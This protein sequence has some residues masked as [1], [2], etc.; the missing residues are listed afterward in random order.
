MARIAFGGFLH[1]VNS[2]TD[3]RAN[4]EYFDGNPAR[5]PFLKGG[6]IIASLQNSGFCPA[7]FIPAWTEQDELVPLVWA[8]GGAGGLVTR[9]AFERIVGELVGR[10]SMAMP[11]DGV[12]V[13]LHGAMVSEDFD[14]AE[15]EILRRIRAVVGPSIPVV[16]SLD[17]HAN[18]SPE[19]AAYCDAMLVYKTYPH[20]DR[21]ETGRRAAQALR[22]LLVLGPAKGRAIRHA[23][24][25]MALDF[26]CTFVEPSKSIVQWQPDC[27]DGLISTSYA[28]GFPP[29]DTVWCG[30]SIVV[31]ALDQASAE[32]AADAY[33]AYFKSLESQFCG[34]L[35]SA[36]EGVAEAKRL[37]STADKP[38][39]LA[40][41]C[42]NP[43]AG[44]TGNTT[45]IIR[46]LLASQA[47]GAVV[48]Y[49]WDPIAA[50]LAFD[51]G[52][53]KT[54]R[55][56]LGEQHPADGEAPL[57]RDFKVVS[58]TDRSY[59]MSGLMARGLEVDFGPMALVQCD[60]V[61]VAVLSQRFQA[62]DRE[63]F[64][65]LG[66]DLTKVKILVLKSSCHFRA[67]FGSLTDTV[68]TVVAP[69]A[70]D[71][72]PANYAYTKLRAGVRFHPDT[73]Q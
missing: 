51:A 34:K 28:A 47:E 40:D 1:E 44:G 41:T 73:P 21:P 15:G 54:V 59:T 52:V 27:S 63:P 22:Q 26:Q 23:S 48:G 67:D 42:D 5:P 65:Q 39:I 38:I 72:D 12:Y 3:L 20:I 9:D 45:G 53:G 35:W 30:P 69:G 50:R 31:H 62:Y 37:A 68:L 6:D 17:Y 13:D 16:I 29:S 43:G 2:F 55:L 11:V 14:D 66:V 19:M 10:L 56:T 60:G 4:Y 57:V 61:Q 36:A 25:M 18:I 70:Y 24:F 58:C 32:A 33:F 46:E 71:P 64:T 7:G 8:N 49:F